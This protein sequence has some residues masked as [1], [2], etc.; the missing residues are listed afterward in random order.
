MKSEMT[1]TSNLKHNGIGAKYLTKSGKIITITGMY[2]DGWYTSDAGGAYNSFGH[3][4]GC[5]PEDDILR[6]IEAK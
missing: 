5:H 1:L 2:G 6:L 3:Y 4:A